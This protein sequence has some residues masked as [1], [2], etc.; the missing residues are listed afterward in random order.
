MQYISHLTLCFSIQTNPNSAQCI[1]HID[2]N[3]LLYNKCQVKVQNAAQKACKRTDVWCHAC[4]II[5]WY[6]MF[7]HITKVK[8]FLHM[9]YGNI[10]LIPSQ[11]VFTKVNCTLMQSSMHLHPN[12]SVLVKPIHTHI[13]HRIIVLKD[14]TPLQNGGL[15][16]SHQIPEVRQIHVSETTSATGTYPKMLGHKHVGHDN[17]L[18]GSRTS[19]VRL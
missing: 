17:T 10:I 12:S 8:H 5:A 16:F 2:I 13:I 6:Y 14:H 19:T 9:Y 7:L 15:G 4:I 18:S 3:C 1:T 11:T